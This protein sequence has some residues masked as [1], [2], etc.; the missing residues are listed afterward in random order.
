MLPF[1]NMNRIL[2]LS[3]SLFLL[4]L[5]ACSTETEAPIPAPAVQSLFQF[6]EAEYDFGTVKQ[7]G[8]IVS[9]DFPFTYVGE[10]PIAISSTPASCACTTAEISQ[11]NFEPGESG[12]LTVFFNPNLHEEPRERFFKSVM[13]VTDPV[14]TP[15]PEI[16]IWLSIDLDLGEEFYELQEEH[17]DDETP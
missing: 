7:S 8:G 1:L 14:L 10:E 6:E 3:F 13:F 2:I 11:K 5:T 16:K 15:P 4:F 9:H 12:V 17:E